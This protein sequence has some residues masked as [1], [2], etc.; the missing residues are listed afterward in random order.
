[1]WVSFDNWQMILDMGSS[2]PVT[3]RHRVIDE[4]PITEGRRSKGRRTKARWLST[5]IKNQLLQRLWI[6]NTCHH[7]AFLCN[8]LNRRK[9]HHSHGHKKVRKP[10]IY[11]FSTGMR[12]LPGRDKHKAAQT[13]TSIANS[14]VHSYSK[15]SM[16]FVVLSSGRSALLT[17]SP[18]QFLVA[19]KSSAGNIFNREVDYITMNCL[20]RTTHKLYLVI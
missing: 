16:R 7:T 12:R 14:S 6:M 10:A 15:R 19:V 9:V 18:K 17:A 2:R 3:D 5:Q 8:S 1:M 11:H 20:L 13:T 4:S